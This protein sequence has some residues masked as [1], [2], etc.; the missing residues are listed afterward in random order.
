MLSRT[1]AGLPRSVMNTGPSA[2]AFLARLVSWLNSRLERVVMV[3]SALLAAPANRHVATSLQFGVCQ[4]HSCSGSSKPAPRGRH[5]IRTKLTGG[6]H[7]LLLV[8]SG[9][10]RPRTSAEVW[11]RSLFAMGPHLLWGRERGGMV[12]LSGIEPLT[13]SLRT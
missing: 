1:W 10:Q 2:A 11:R 6:R 7:K 3:M 4:R 13:S 5:A 9:D 8:I 12:E